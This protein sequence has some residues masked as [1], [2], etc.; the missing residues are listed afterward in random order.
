MH[1]SP[2]RQ[3]GSSIPAEGGNENRKHR[4]MKPLAVEK[5]VD[6]FTCREHRG[7]D[8]KKLVLIMDVCV[9]DRVGMKKAEV[10]LEI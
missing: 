3:Y 8:D 7:Q 5:N 2:G 6:N 1:C 10:R 4:G 9:S